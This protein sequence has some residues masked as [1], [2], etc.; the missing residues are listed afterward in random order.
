MHLLKK[1]I[2]FLDQERHS[3]LCAQNTHELQRW[4]NKSFWERKSDSQSLVFRI[5]TLLPDIAELILPEL[6]KSVRK[7]T[8]FMEAM[9]ALQEDQAFSLSRPKNSAPAR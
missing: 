6:R 1:Q 2:P 3:Q 5:I 4:S 7:W 9:T 8:P